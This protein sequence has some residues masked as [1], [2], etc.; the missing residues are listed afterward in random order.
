MPRGSFISYYTMEDSRPLYTAAARLTKLR[1]AGVCIIRHSIYENRTMGLRWP[2]GE[3]LILMKQ[4][5]L[6]KLPAFFLSGKSR[7]V[8]H[9]RAQQRHRD[10]QGDERSR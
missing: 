5:A 2:H 6:S 3:P 4:A 8:G 1:S 10:A 9:L 7:R